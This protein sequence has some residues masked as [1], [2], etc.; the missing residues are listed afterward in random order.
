MSTNQYLQVSMDLSENE[1]VLLQNVEFTV[2]SLKEAQFNL[3]LARKDLQDAESMCRVAK[4]ALYEHQSRLLRRGLVDPEIHERPSYLGSAPA[5]DY[6]DHL[7]GTDSRFRTTDLSQ[8]WKKS[9]SDLGRPRFGLRTLY[10]R[11]FP[12]SRKKDQ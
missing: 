3:D 4:L 9:T 10:H 2:Q 11:F 5:E 8:D 7:T 12:V 6:L 1:G